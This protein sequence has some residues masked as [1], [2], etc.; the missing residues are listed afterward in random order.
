LSERW[1][2]VIRKKDNQTV[3]NQWFL[4]GEGSGINSIILDANFRDSGI[5]TGK[6][7]RNR[8]P[9]LMGNQYQSFGCPS[10]NILGLDEKP[11]YIQCDNRH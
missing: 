8:P 4:P 6:I 9:I 3:F 10:I 7:L 2:I 11:I 5:W 1:V